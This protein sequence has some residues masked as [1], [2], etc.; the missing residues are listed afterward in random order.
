MLENKIDEEKLKEKKQNYII[1]EKEREET[2]DGGIVF[3]NAKASIFINSL[4]GF[5]AIGLILLNNALDGDFAKMFRYISLAMKTGDFKLVAIIALILLASFLISLLLSYFRW[6]NTSIIFYTNY[7][8]FKKQGIR[9]NEKKVAYINV[10]NVTRKGSLSAQILGAEMLG[11]DI[12]SAQTAKD[13]DYSIILSKNDSKKFQNIIFARQ[14]G[15]ELL[16]ENLLDACGLYEENKNGVINNREL[17]KKAEKDDAIIYE[18]MFTGKEKLRHIFLSIGMSA[19]IGVVSAMGIIV[20]GLVY[21]QGAV[22]VV[23]L[24]F[25]ISGFKNIY[26]NINKYKGFTVKRTLDTVHVNYGLFDTRAYA[27][28]VDK[29]MSVNISSGLLARIFRCSIVNFEVVGVVNKSDESNN[30]GIYIKNLELPLFM[31]RL[32]P[33]FPLSD[34]SFEKQDKI[35]ALLSVLIRGAF[36]GTI[37]FGLQYIGLCKYAYEVN[38]WIYYGGLAFIA[39]LMLSKILME[40]F[41][42]AVIIDADRVMIRSGSFATKTETIY[43]D[44]IDQIEINESAIEKLLGLAKLDMYLRNSSGKTTVETGYFKREKFEAIAERFVRGNYDNEI[45]K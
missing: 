2:D 23:L 6:K 43:F 22:V 24:P 41:S 31:E 39:Y 15:D 9:K 20:G 29:I 34:K 42:K 27:I 3:R 28:K 35:A 32:I 26:S 40:F 12:N 33:E 30:L 11:I 13:D 5:V 4:G 1:E 7:I 36:L 19:V 17:I 45:D 16:N 18:R 14:R 44:K 21:K 8:K 38:H 37:Y 25:I 10:T